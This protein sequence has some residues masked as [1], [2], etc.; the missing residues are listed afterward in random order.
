MGRESPSDTSATRLVVR[1]ALVEQSS[2]PPP[3]EPFDGLIRPSEAGRP[4]T[5]NT[6]CPGQRDLTVRARLTLVTDLF[7]VLTQHRGSAQ[8]PEA[9]HQHHPHGQPGVGHRAHPSRRTTSPT[10]LEHRPRATV[11]AVLPLLPRGR[12]ASSPRALHPSQ[13]AGHGASPSRLAGTV[14]PGPRSQ[15][16][17]RPV[18]RGVRRH[19]ARR[20]ARTMHR[21]RVRADRGV[22]R[23]SRALAGGRQASGVQVEHP[24]RRPH[25]SLRRGEAS[26]ETPPTVVPSVDDA[27]LPTLAPTA[28][29][30]YWPAGRV[31]LA[32]HRSAPS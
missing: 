24:G 20:R 16:S 12:R 1:P 23:A 19:T 21:R 26:Q 9:A 7:S 18:P 15:A 2:A 8:R 28:G 27:E 5:T 6:V 32:S 4:S 3:A 13:A 10:H 17:N 14:L 22:P 29:T 11:I 30:A 31:G 25:R